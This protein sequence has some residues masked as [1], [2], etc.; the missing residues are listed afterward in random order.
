MAE[1]QPGAAFLTNVKGRW[2]FVKNTFHPRYLQM[3]RGA[4]FV[5]HPRKL[6][7]ISWATGKTVSAWAFLTD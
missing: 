5:R 3:L 2:T 1:A 4:T 7:R 6:F